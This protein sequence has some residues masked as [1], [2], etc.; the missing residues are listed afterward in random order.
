M[1]WGLRSREQPAGYPW[2]NRSELSHEL[3]NMEKDGLLTV[4]KNPFVVLF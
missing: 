3:K 1:W 4:R 2:L